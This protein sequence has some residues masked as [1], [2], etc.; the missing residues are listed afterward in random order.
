MKLNLL[1]GRSA[2]ENPKQIA[3]KTTDCRERRAPV[4]QFSSRRKRTNAPGTKPGY[5]ATNLGGHWD[6]R[7]RRHAAVQPHERSGDDPIAPGKPSSD[8]DVASADLVAP[9]TD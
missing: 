3:V 9:A 5:G 6:D 1:K 8:L 2:E 4:F 7:I